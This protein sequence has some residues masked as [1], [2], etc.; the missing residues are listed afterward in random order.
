MLLFI[1]YVVTQL[2]QATY[3]AIGLRPH[4]WSIVVAKA[5]TQGQKRSQGARPERTLLWA[6]STRDG[7]W[8]HC[9]HLQPES[10]K[11][12]MIHE[13]NWGQVK[14]QRLRNSDL[15]AG[16]YLRTLSSHWKSGVMVSSTFSVER[17]I[18]CRWTARSSLG[19]WCTY[20]WMVLPIFG[21]RMSSPNKKRRL[22][23]VKGELRGAVLRDDT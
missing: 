3:K 12:L 17:V 19:N 11:P 9:P 14:C 20:L 8:P 16:Q 22:H 10:R 7:E 1:N 15:S 2:N 6:G 5:Q 18:G 23:H 21:I 13:S 4:E